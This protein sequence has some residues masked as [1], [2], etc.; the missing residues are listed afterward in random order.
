[1]ICWSLNRDVAVVGLAVEAGIGVYMRHI[2]LISAPFFRGDCCMVA[3]P[4]LQGSK[5]IIRSTSHLDIG[6]SVG[7]IG[8]IVVM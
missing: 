2:L 1:M 4:D 3:D 6:S 7:S 8:H 5:T